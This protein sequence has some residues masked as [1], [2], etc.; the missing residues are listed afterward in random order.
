MTNTTKFT[1]AALFSALV[2]GAAFAGTNNVSADEAKVNSETGYAYVGYT[3]T[4]APD[5]LDPGDPDNPT[6]K[7][8]DPGITKE[9]G[10][11]T[12]DAIPASLNFG[13]QEA[14]G[15][16]QV[17]KLLQD[18]GTATD[19]RAMATGKDGK[20]TAT[21]NHQ[22]ENGTDQVIFTQV[23]DVAGWKPT[24]HLTATMSEFASDKGGSLPGAYI[25]FAGGKN[26]IK[27]VDAE[28]GGTKWSDAKG[29]TSGDITLVAG[30][31][32]TGTGVAD[33]VSTSDTGTF[34]Q[35]WAVDQVSLTTPQAPTEG[36][37]SATINWILSADPATYT[38]P[39]PEDPAVDP[40][41]EG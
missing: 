13:T 23:T 34:Q 12:L 39:A 33:I 16:G 36:Q 28:N 38:A 19:T 24:W 11:L 22:R 29:L 21:N 35:Q 37:Y 8:D 7:P 32:T 4:T 2:L 5:V 40:N 27:S 3:A 18:G 17:V 26:V 14:T 10:S 25:T 20:G 1:A 41:A 30:S 9:T 6:I 31:D 15:A